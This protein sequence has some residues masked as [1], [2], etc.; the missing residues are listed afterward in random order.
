MRVLFATLPYKA[1]LYAQV[2]VAWALRSAGHEVRVASRPDLVDDI[3]HTG[4]TAVPVGEPLDLEGKMAANHADDGAP[5][6]EDLMRMDELR[7]EKL[8]Y[9]HTH[10]RFSTMTATAFPLA[11]SVRTVDEIVDFARTWR[12]DLLVWDSLFFAGAV[13]ARACGAAHARLLYG[14]DLLGWMR[15]GYLKAVHGRPPELRDD[16]VREWLGW[17][18]EQYGCDYGEDAFMGRWTIDPVPSSMRLAVEH[19]YVPVRHVPYNGR[20]VIEGWLREPPKRR[21]VCLTLGLSFREFMGG[22]RVSVAR[23]LEAV[24]DLDAEVVATFNAEQMAGVSSVPDNVRV[25]DFAPM[26]ELLPTCS[27]I[28]HQGGFGQALTAQAHGVPQVVLP[29]GLWDTVARGR[30]LQ[31]A[32]AGLCAPADGISADE[33]RRMLVRVLEE[34]RFAEGAA[35]L[36]AE[37]LGTP[38]PAGIVPL[39]EKLTDEHREH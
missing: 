12:P 21:R 2:P 14:L 35:G 31:D 13:A 17:T 19:P 22:D 34:P 11:S 9:D 37:M 20:S 15:Q 3:T 4:L 36:R 25:V 29:N 5:E 8:T 7:A 33:L 26:N 6:V 24:A 1:H 39:L 23:L 10:E 30:R 27:A 38:A 32:G 18:L 28:V 16:P